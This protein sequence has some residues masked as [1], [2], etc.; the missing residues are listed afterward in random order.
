MANDRTT[1]IEVPDRGSSG[2]GW[3]IAVVLVVALILGA[4]FFSRLTGSET[5]KDNAVAN[6]AHQ[7]GNAASNVG[8]AAKDSTGNGK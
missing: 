8:D 3:V 6:A 4:V 2:A 7:V 1:V 5:A